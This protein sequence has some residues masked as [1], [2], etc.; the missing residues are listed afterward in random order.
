MISRHC[1][2]DS[3]RHAVMHTHAIST[4]LWIFEKLRARCHLSISVAVSVTPGAHMGSSEALRGSLVMPY[5]RPNS[6]PSGPN[7]SPVQP[8]SAVRLPLHNMVTTR[9]L[10]SRARHCAQHITKVVTN[11][12][13]D[14]R[15][16]QRGLQVGEPTM[17]AEGS[18]ATRICRRRRA[19]RV[20]A[21]AAARAAPRV[22]QIREAVNI[23]SIAMQTQV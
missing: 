22:S 14:M 13:T 8:R 18:R 4:M 2:Q 20:A 16:R 17:L 23:K 3:D 15:I 6:G 1:N 21:R 11:T 7:C 10:T 19:Q 9:S 12:L 5:S